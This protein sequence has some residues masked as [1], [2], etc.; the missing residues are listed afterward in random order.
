MGYVGGGLGPRLARR[1]GRDLVAVESG[2]ACIVLLLYG[3]V[4][5]V[6]RLRLE[7]QLGRLVA[8]HFHLLELDVFPLVERD[9]THEAQVHAQTAVFART[10]EADEYAIGHAHP[11]RIMGSAFET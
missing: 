2:R 1:F 4:R 3:H 7:E 6:A 8:A 11:L 5:L 9:R 10:L